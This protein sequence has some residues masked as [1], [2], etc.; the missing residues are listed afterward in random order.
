M[1]TSNIMDSL[2]L[3]SESNRILE[4]TGVHIFP[5]LVVALV[6]GSTDVLIAKASI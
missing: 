1:N 2:P 5:F 6:W 3:D 4:I